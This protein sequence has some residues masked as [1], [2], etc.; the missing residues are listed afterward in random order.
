MY[1]YQLYH[2]DFCCSI[3]IHQHSNTIDNA[4]RKLCK[5]YVYIF[6][7][8]RMC[9]TTYR[10]RHCA[11]YTHTHTHLHLYMYTLHLIHALARK[12]QM[13]AINRC[14][15]KIIT[16]ICPEDERTTLVSAKKLSSRI[17]Q[18]TFTSFIAYLRLSLSLVSKSLL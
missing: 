3:Q 6:L 8:M 15:I 9:D 2:I 7:E 1:L 4:S 17:R 5:I 14:L 10:L 13:I 12:T 16:V 18:A 11:A